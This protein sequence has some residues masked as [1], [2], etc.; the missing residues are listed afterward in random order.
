MK[1]IAILGHGVVGRG[2]AQMLTANADKI[3]RLVGEEVRIKYILDI[4]ELP[5]SPWY[6]R[7]V[8][9]F[10]VILNDPDVVLVAEAIGGLHPA[11]EYSLAALRAGKH[12]VTSNKACVSR[13]GGPLTRAAEASGVS[14]LFEASCGG[15]IPLISPLLHNLSHNHITSVA[16]ILNGTTNYILTRMKEGGL[17]FD[18][19]LAEAQAK[20]YAEQDPTA[21]V[22]GFDAARKINIITAVLT[23]KLH[24]EDD[25]YTEGIRGVRGV[26][27]LAAEKAGYAVKLLGR[28][29]DGVLFV[30]PHMVPATSPLAHV[31]DVFNAVMV[32]GDF[33]GDVMLYGQGAGAEATASAVVA[34]IIEALKHNTIVPPFRVTHVLLEFP[35]YACPRYLSV[36]EEDKAL[37]L[38]LL[39]VPYEVMEVAEGEFACIV[40]SM[41]EGELD[42]L[43]GKI[44]LRA[45]LRVLE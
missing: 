21:D 26:D 31:N 2:T 24:E 43:K 17:S 12:V 27:V 10:N 14:Y 1:Q 34:D 16:G 30:S 6:D 33:V 32:H 4:R 19:A 9:N 25:I 13:F 22:D 35:F 11:Y 15:G 38:S 44:S 39:H 8:H 18:T 40:S 42:H 37:L 45:H 23:G 29:A 7:I 36:A 41:R 5:D 3:K 28:L 20:G